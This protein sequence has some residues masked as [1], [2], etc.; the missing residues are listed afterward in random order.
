MGGLGW[1]VRGL[2]TELRK[3]LLVG[4]SSRFSIG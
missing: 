4:T 3:A 2:W 1:V